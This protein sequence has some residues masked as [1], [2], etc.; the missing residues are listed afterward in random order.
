MRQT[1]IGV[2]G[3]GDKAS[4]ADLK[5]AGE[6]G[7]LI[8]EKKWT[9]L[10]GGRSEGVMDAASKAA[11]QA[12]G[13]TIGVLP[14]K[15]FDQTQVSP[16]VDFVILTGMEE[17]RNLINVLTSDVVLVCGMGSGT[18]SEVALALKTERPVVLVA[19]DPQVARFFASLGDPKIASDA[20]HA[21]QIVTNLLR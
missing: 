16:W 1:I 9:L 15:T 21:I 20:E 13:Q 14:F 7:R 3:P 10:T 6:L 12:G 18:A 19:P 17:A 8:A 5:L 11:K 2:M 4:Q